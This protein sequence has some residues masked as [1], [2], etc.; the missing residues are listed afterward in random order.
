MPGLML[1][2]AVALL[3]WSIPRKRDIY[4]FQED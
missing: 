4:L 2:V 1:I 3:V